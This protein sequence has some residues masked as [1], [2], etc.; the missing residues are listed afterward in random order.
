MK[1]LEDVLKIAKEDYV[2]VLS[3]HAADCVRTGVGKLYDQGRKFAAA[4]IDPLLV[5]YNVTAAIGNIYRGYNRI[6]P[7][8]GQACP[9]S[10]RAE[11]ADTSV[12]TSRSHCAQGTVQG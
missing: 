1:W 3:A 4:R 8:A 7:P 11:Q 6:E 5:K 10:S 2:L 12:S 9:R